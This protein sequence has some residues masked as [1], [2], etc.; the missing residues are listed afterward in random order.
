MQQNGNSIIIRHAFQARARGHP[1]IQHRKR[2]G[3]VHT[4]Q[5]LHNRTRPE[6]LPGDDHR[7]RD[8]QD[9]RQQVQE[10]AKRHQDVQQVLPAGADKFL[11]VDGDGVRRKETALLLRHL[12]VVYRLRRKLPEHHRA[13]FPEGFH[14][15]VYVLRDKHERRWFP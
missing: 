6:P 11:L 4:L 15:P 13:L 14:S 1:Q 3:V 8:Q 7:L 10:F 9:R 12:L 5:R 2:Q